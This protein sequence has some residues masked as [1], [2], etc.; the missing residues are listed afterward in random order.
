MSTGI[1]PRIVTVGHVTILV[2]DDLREDVRIWEQY[3]YWPKE[4]HDAGKR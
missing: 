4:R 2:V 1:A 3:A